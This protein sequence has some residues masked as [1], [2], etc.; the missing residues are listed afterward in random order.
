MIALRKPIVSTEPSAF[1]TS[2]VFASRNVP[3]PSNSVMPFF[4]IRK[5]TPLT[6][7]SD[8]WRLRS[9]AAP[10]SKCTSP[11]M[12]KVVAWSWKMCASSALR[13]SAFEGMHPTLR[14]TPPQ[15]LS[16]MTATFRP[17]CA[18]RIAAT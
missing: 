5:C 2:I 6:C 4:F 8:T 13:S 11:E 18:A 3:R 10:K 14:H 7:F 16:S 1:V 15:Y 9:N 17:S 12:P